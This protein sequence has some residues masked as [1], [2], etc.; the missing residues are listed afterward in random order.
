[1]GYTKNREIEAECSSADQ[2]GKMLRHVFCLI[3]SIVLASPSVAMA[4][5]AR[6]EMAQI[7][8]RLT[9]GGQKEVSQLRSDCDRFFYLLLDRVSYYPE[10]QL[11]EVIILTPLRIIIVILQDRVGIIFTEEGTPILIIS[12]LK[13]R[14]RRLII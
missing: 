1:M 10:F 5:P 7:H 13:M 8:G 2:S 14:A 6:T 9:S 4:E 12:C 3:S 11:R